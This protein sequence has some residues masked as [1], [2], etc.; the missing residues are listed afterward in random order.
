MYLTYIRLQLLPQFGKITKLRMLGVSHHDLITQEMVRKV[1][2]IF[3]YAR[4][5]NL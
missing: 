4:K 2:D 5:R 3:Q 1:A